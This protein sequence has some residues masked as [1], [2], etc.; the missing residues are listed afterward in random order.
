[1]MKINKGNLTASYAREQSKSIGLSVSK[2][3]QYEITI[4]VINVFEKEIEK[5]IN[6]GENHVDIELGYYGGFL[7]TRKHWWY[8]F[9]KILDLGANIIVAYFEEKGFEVCYT[10]LGLEMDPEAHISW[11]SK[12]RYSGIYQDELLEFYKYYKETRR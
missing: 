12:G 4:K 9:N 11:V 6:K 7:I 1:M 8:Q 10:G 3:R 5:A 2:K